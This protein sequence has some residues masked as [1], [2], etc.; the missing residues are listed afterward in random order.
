[1]A[2]NTVRERARRTFSWIEVVVAGSPVAAVG[3]SV[4]PLDVVRALSVAVAGA[5][6][7]AA[8]VN[9]IT[10]YQFHS[11]FFLPISIIFYWMIDFDDK[12]LE[13]SNEVDIQAHII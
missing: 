11:F 10:S 1:M 8:L 2:S 3:L 13:K 5:V 6:A 7:S 4:D 12:N 9:P